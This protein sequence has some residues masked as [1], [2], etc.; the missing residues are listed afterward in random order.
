MHFLLPL[1][2]LCDFQSRSLRIRTLKGALIS[3][4][5]PIVT[6]LCIFPKK[7]HV[8]LQYSS[9]ECPF[10]TVL[11]DLRDI[12]PEQNAF[13]G[14]YFQLGAP[15][16]SEWCLRGRNKYIGLCWQ[17]LC[18]KSSCWTKNP[19]FRNCQS[20]EWQWIGGCLWNALN[21]MWNLSLCPTR[22]MGWEWK[23]LLFHMGSVQNLAFDVFA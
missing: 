6:A 15:S 4:L 12:P 8:S 14:F 2:Y 18:K 7:T 21:L 19:R 3:L 17:Q 1:K 20:L 11:V 22:S 13:Q 16:I 23:C 9:A 10:W 5:S